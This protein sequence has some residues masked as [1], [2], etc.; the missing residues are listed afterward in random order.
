MQNRPAVPLAIVGLTVAITGIAWAGPR[1]IPLAITTCASSSACY[2]AT[3][4]SSGPAIL[5]SAAAGTGVRGATSG[6]AAAAG[7]YGYATAGGTGVIGVS[8][9]SAGVEGRSSTANGIFADSAGAAPAVAGSDSSTGYA[10][11]GIASKGTAVESSGALQAFAGTGQFASTA[12]SGDLLHLVNS[13]GITVFS[14]D[15]AGDLYF[16]GPELACA[17][18]YNSTNSACEGESKPPADASPHAPTQLQLRAG[19]VVRLVRYGQASLSAGSARVALDPAL[20]HALVSTRSYHVFL[21]GQSSSADWLYVA[22]KTQAGFVVRSH[23]TDRSNGSFGYRIVADVL[24]APA[25]TVK[26]PL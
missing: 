23:G 13:Q 24:P 19:E 17:R 25:S 12:S 15:Q 6:S 18:Y 21:T 22:E 11:E 10:V 5:G 1:V 26:R 8:S 7:V 14:I 9:S 4:K 2:S 16:Y 20:S 3:N